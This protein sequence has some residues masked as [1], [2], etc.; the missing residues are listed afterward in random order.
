MT[1]CKEDD[2]SDGI[3]LLHR[4]VMKADLS[5]PGELLAKQVLERV[6]EL[7]PSDIHDDQTILILKA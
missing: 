5:L 4:A 6:N 7:R 2:A 1:E 3:D